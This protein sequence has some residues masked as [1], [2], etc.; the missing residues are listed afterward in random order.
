MSKT[1]RLLSYPELL[2]KAMKLTV[3]GNCKQTM[4]G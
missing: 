3:E 1:V 2:T 4:G